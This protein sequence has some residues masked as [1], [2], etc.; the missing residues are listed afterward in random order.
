MLP[1]LKEVETL[2]IVVCCHHPSHAAII[3]IIAAGKVGL[4]GGSSFI[5]V[6][7][8]LYINAD[9]NITN[10]NTKNS[11]ISNLI[12]YIPNVSRNSK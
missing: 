10:Q 9:I 6:P 12:N 1:L 8:A 7:A 5:T 4:V 3:F 11:F 2:G